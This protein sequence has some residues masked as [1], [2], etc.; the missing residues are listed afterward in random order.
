MKKSYKRIRLLVFLMSSAVVPVAWAQ[1]QNHSQANVAISVQEEAVSS[2]PWAEATVFFNKGMLDD[3]GSD[4][5]IQNLKIKSQD[6]SQDLPQRTKSLRLASLVAWKSGDLAQAL[7]IAAQAVKMRASA[8]NLYQLAQVSDAAGELDQAEDTYKSALK[9]SP[10]EEMAAEIRLQLAL[11]EAMDKDVDAYLRL[12]NAMDPIRKNRVAITLALMR[13]PGEA[14]SLYVPVKGNSKEAVAGH[15]RMAGWAIG[16]KDLD[17]AKAHAWKAVTLA[18]EKRERLYG[19]SLLV[20]AHRMDDSLGDLIKTFSTSKNISAEAREVWINLLHETGRA[21]EAMELFR[22]GSDGNFTPKERIRLIGLYQSGGDDRAVVGEYQKLIKTEPDEVYWYIG[23]SEHY[24]VK[25]LDRDAKQVWLDFLNTNLKADVLLGGAEAM[26]EMGFFVEAIEASELA[27]KR[28]KSPVTGLM[29][30]FEHYLGRDKTAEAKSVLGRLMPHFPDGSAQRYALADSYERIGESEIALQIWETLLD[31]P[32]LFGIDETMRLAWLYR[33]LERDEDALTI[34]KDLQKEH[35]SPAVR[36]IV[37]QQLLILSA[38]LGVLGDL[39][40]ELEDSLSAGTST[41]SDSAFLARIYIRVEDKVSAIEIITEF[42]KKSGG[43]AVESLKEQAKVYLLMNDFIN[44]GKISE[45]LMEVDPENTSE[46]LRDSILSKVELLGDGGDA[47]KNLAELKNKLK[48]FRVQDTQ[49]TGRQFEGG[50]LSLAYQDEDAITA[51]LQAIAETPNNGDYYL[52]LG[53]ILTRLGR[54]E[55]AFSLFQ[56]LVVETDSDEMFVSAIDGVM[57]T[58]GPADSGGTLSKRNGAMLGWLQ[59]AIYA[60]LTREEDKFY[61]YQLLY[62]VI[63]ETGDA[64]A[65]IEVLGDSLATA[66]DRRMSILRELISMTMSDESA[67]H[68]HGGSKTAGEN[69]QNNFGRRL[70]GLQQAL[71]PGIYMSLA[72]SFIANEDP[73]GAEKSVNKAVEESGQTKLRADAGAMFE[74]HG[75]DFRAINQYRR[76]LIR[77]RNDFSLMVNVARL[78]E[79]VGQDQGANELFGQSLELLLLRQKQIVPVSPKTTVKDMGDYTE[80]R[81]NDTTKTIEYKAYY[82]SVLQ[83]FMTT[84]QDDLGVMKDK[85]DRFESLFMEELKFAVSEMTDQKDPIEK[86]SRLNHLGIFLRSVSLAIGDYDR[87]E[88]IDDK[89]IQKFSHDDDF[90]FTL[91]KTRLDRGLKK[92]AVWVAAQARKTD[93]GLSARSA[94]LL[95][96]WTESR[97][98]TFTQKL[99]LAKESKEF[100]S[101]L[102]MVFASGDESKLLLTLR[103]WAQAGFYLEAFKWSKDNL[104]PEHHKNLSSYLVQLIRKN[105]TFFFKAILQDQN[106][107]PDLE[108][109][110]GESVFSDRELLIL[111]EDDRVSE[112]KQFMMPSVLKRIS[113]KSRLENLQASL[114]DMGKDDSALAVLSPFWL[115]FVGTPQDETTAAQFAKITMDI[116]AKAP[117]RGET[118][119]MGNVTVSFSDTL[120]TFE[121]TLFGPKV[122]SEN[123]VWVKEVMDY[124]RKLASVEIDIFRPVDLLLTGQTDAAVDAVID[125]FLEIIETNKGDSG[126]IGGYNLHYEKY[127]FPKHRDAMRENILARE[128]RNGPT[129]ALSELY[130][131][132][133]LSGGG[134]MDVERENFLRQKSKQFPLNPKYLGQ[135]KQAFD[136][137]EL[138]W[139]SIDLLKRLLESEPKN[140]MYRGALFLDLIR[141]DRIQEAMALNGRGAEDM[142]SDGYFANLENIAK[143][144]GFAF[145]HNEYDQFAGRVTG[146]STGVT[147]PVAGDPAKNPVKIISLKLAKAV[148]AEDQNEM[149]NQLRALWQTVLKNNRPPWMPLDQFDIEK[150]GKYIEIINLDWPAEADPIHRGRKLFDVISDYEFSLE[151]F[152][153]FIRAKRIDRKSG[154]NALYQY[155]VKSYENQGLA[156]EVFKEMSKEIRSGNGNIGQGEFVLWLNFAE[157][158]KTVASGALLK[159]IEGWYTGRAN[160]SPDVLR[161]LARL[162]ARAGQKDK[163]LDIYK[164]LADQSLFMKFPRLEF[165]FQMEF[166]YVHQGQ[167]TARELIA[168]GVQNLE[169]QQRKQLLDYILVRVNGLAGRDHRLR[170]MADLF[171]LEALRLSLPPEET[172]TR[173][174]QLDTETAE[175]HPVNALAL[176]GLYVKTGQTEQASKQLKIMVKLFSELRAKSIIELEWHS[177][178]GNER[179]GKVGQVFAEL[180]GYPV[181]YLTEIE[182]IVLADV[183]LGAL[184]D[185][186]QNWPWL[187]QAGDDLSTLM[188]AP[189][190]DRHMIIGMMVNIGY[191][192][193]KGGKEAEVKR[194]LG[195]LSQ[196]MKAKAFSGEMIEKTFSLARDAEVPLDIEIAKWLLKN[197]QL[198]KAAILETVERVRK[199]EGT[200]AALKLARS[201]ADYTRFD[202]LLGVLTNLSKTA[203]MNEQADE[204]AQERADSARL[205]DRLQTILATA[206]EVPIHK[207]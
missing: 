1:S 83:G 104:G 48:L 18:V 102:N 93:A 92:S 90:I 22:S 123:R 149:R 162:Y 178:T 154:L 148:K 100:D 181:S 106:F 112:Y 190:M 23:L 120:F 49:G 188:N 159:D 155:L 137:T 44:Y 34:W 199:M 175:E 197:G 177:H 180:I 15:M 195:L 35:L 24:A 152:K 201:A 53:S 68:T 86:Y 138:P 98:D 168:E 145:E 163:S 85:I 133:F 118:G 130:S 122:A 196:A 187:V 169:D 140:A 84:W 66:E 28:S 59:R 41:K 174:G 89:L 91:L 126:S 6:T 19:L 56:A 50:V 203:G 40:F 117:L 142:L 115:S 182:P 125:T 82:A 47:D 161:L 176:T 74:K 94:R 135:L 193:H 43:D 45:R 7:E 141:A 3:G 54:A 191:R 9:A 157:R 60:R 116:L 183:Y 79:K 202:G 33:S 206:P 62:D 46:Y 129:E 63:S 67:G 131:L 204:W 108:Q 136:K 172:R 160:L 189:G 42:F 30:L 16:V 73:Y 186:D 103:A 179:A 146:F 57:N 4:I 127:F 185:D 78:R 58:F 128:K 101:V 75:Y 147:V 76:A 37:E 36:S 198:D 109:A 31:T 55:E 20:E 164:T 25:G 70:V 134:M 132:L 113:S 8:D 151:E 139:W 200:G 184:G 29:S 38:E 153:S 171:V 11:I 121:G 150:L 97:T 207:Y 61:Y 69:T 10:S 192:L 166:L 165:V 158:M 14:L 156:E 27:I 167:L 99:A 111:V 194:I 119:Q 144:Q 21:T 51:F 170:Q 88:H 64:K 96:S 2:L 12:A 13:Y 87:A 107:F 77:N 110:A 80:V 39:V 72:A 81:Y 143:K 105:K 205:E 95:T 114:R 32:G 71:P 52:Q 124:W 173:L 26:T 65:Q 17:K 5:V